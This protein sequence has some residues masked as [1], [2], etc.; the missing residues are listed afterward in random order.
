M[1]FTISKAKLHN[2][3]KMS[4][5]KKSEILFCYLLAALPLLQFC[6]FYIFVNFN[7]I[8]MTFQTYTV[9]DGV[10]SWEPVGF[11]NYE[12]AFEMLFSSTFKSMWKNSITAYLVGILI[13]TPLGLLFSNY[14]YKKYFGSK[15][16]KVILYLPSIISTMT[17]SVFFLYIANYVLPEIF[18]LEVGLFTNKD[19][20]FP[21]AM[22]FTIWAGFGGSVIIYESTMSSISESVVEAATLDGATG[23]KEFFYITLPLVYPTISMFVSV[24]ITSVFTNQ[25]SLFNFFGTDCMNRFSTIGYYLYKNIST[26]NYKDHSYLATLGVIFTFISIILVYTTKYLMKKLGPSVEE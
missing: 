25:V 5:R 14:I 23:F 13:S 11:D 24:G 17:I 10:A 20:R 16:F 12:Y 22:L 21:T 6:I 19:T 9:V 15:I 2:K 4:P 26:S 3:R 8:T 7:T 1:N 18:G